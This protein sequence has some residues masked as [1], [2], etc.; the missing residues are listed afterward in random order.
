[1]HPLFSE[2]KHVVELA[3]RDGPSITIKFKTFQEKE[4]WMSSIMSVYLK[5]CVY[6]LGGGGVGGGYD[7]FWDGPFCIRISIC[8]LFRLFGLVLWTEYLIKFYENMNR[9]RH[10]DYQVLMFIGE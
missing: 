10:Y 1:V 8:D 9:R 7:L 2:S 5:R 6:D 4:E 3:D